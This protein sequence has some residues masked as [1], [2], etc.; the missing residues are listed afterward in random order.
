MSAGRVSSTPHDPTQEQALGNR[1]WMDAEMQ[2]CRQLV[3]LV[4][5]NTVIS[6]RCS[7]SSCSYHCFQQ[8]SGGTTE[9]PC[10]ILEFYCH[11]SPQN[12]WLQDAGRCRARVLGGTNR[13]FSLSATFSSFSPLQMNL[14]VQLR[15]KRPTLLMHRQG[16]INTNLSMKNGF[17]QKTVGGRRQCT[18]SRHVC[19]FPDVAWWLVSRTSR[20]KRTKSV[21]ETWGNKYNSRSIFLS[22][23]VSECDEHCG[24][25][26]FTPTFFNAMT[27]RT[28]L[29]AT[30]LFKPSS[31]LS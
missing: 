28:A 5:C 17:I 26:V 7:L 21:G 22:A 31:I 29:T 27:I 25:T 23:R 1:R 4:R 20:L 30:R 14:S 11:P 19:L 12:K 15:Y 3:L 2:W 10:P 18:D 6:C 8:L 24:C 16:A 13:F 9:S